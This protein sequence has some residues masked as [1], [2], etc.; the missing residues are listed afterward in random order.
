MSKASPE[1]APESAPELAILIVSDIDAVVSVLKMGRII[2][3]QSGAYKR[4]RVYPVSRFHSK[5]I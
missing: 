1:L 2:F 5:R 4:Q 3:P